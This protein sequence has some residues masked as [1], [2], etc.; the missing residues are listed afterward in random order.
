MI[1]VSILATQLTAAAKKMYNLRYEMSNGGNISIRIPGTDLMLIKGTNVAFDEINES[2]LVVTDFD[3]KVVQGTIKPSK[4][5]LLHGYLYRNFPEVGAIMHCHSPYSIA[6][7]A[8]HESLAFSTHHAEL[9]L[10]ACP[11]VDTHSY[12]VPPECF[13]LVL[14]AVKQVEGTN[15]FILRAHGQVAMAKDMREATYLAELVEETAQI[16]VLTEAMK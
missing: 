8:N 14:D 11:V 1:D 7:A 9:K 13:P 5:G 10:K 6:W 12:A 3:G 16:A 15:A 2:N 4:E